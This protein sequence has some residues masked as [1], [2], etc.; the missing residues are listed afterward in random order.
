ME[1]N[2]LRAYGREFGSRKAFCRGLGGRKLKRLGDDYRDLEVS[3]I[4]VLIGDG[5]GKLTSYRQGAPSSRHAAQ[6]P[7]KASRSDTHVYIIPPCQMSD[8]QNKSARANSTD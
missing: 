7:S 1:S 4:W 8:I 3:H 2:R 6:K 5:G